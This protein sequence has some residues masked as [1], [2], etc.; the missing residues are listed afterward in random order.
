MSEIE[1]P[2]HYEVA[3]RNRIKANANKTRRRKFEAA[4]ANDSDDFKSWI[5]NVTPMALRPLESACYNRFGSVEDEEPHRVFRAA[6][7]AWRDRVGYPADFLAE[8]IHDW[9]GLTDGQLAYARKSFAESGAKLAER[10]EA[11]AERRANAPAWVKGRQIVTGTVVST[12]REETDFGPT[13]KMLLSLED[14]RKLWCSVPSAL[15][16]SDLKARIVTMNVTVT[17][18]ATD[19]SFAFGSRPSKAIFAETT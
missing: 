3:V 2:D 10:T 17:P 15:M 6:M 19:H 7:K 16:R 5:T 4:I 9:G 11:E 13:W 14:G 12:R 8:A 1:Y 18:S